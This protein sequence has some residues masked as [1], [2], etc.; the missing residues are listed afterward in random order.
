[1]ST[2]LRVG[3]I[4]YFGKDQ[5]RYYKVLIMKDNKIIRIKTVKSPVKEGFDM[6]GSTHT[7]SWDSSGCTLVKRDY[8]DRRPPWF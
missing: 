5:D 8:K 3:D 6:L 1:M 2:K 4:F 7:S